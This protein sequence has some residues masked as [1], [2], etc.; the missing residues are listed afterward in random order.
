MIYVQNALF[1]VI[2][3]FLEEKMPERQLISSN[4]V[5]QTVVPN[6]THPLHRDWEGQSR[7]FP[8][9]AMIEQ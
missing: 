9:E 5:H 1:K 3:S 2:Q 6:D 7:S 4:K 8:R